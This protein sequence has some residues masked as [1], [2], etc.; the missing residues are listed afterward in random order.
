MLPCI[1]SIIV[2]ATYVVVATAAVIG[3]ASVVIV[4]T[5]R[6]VRTIE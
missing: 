2:V 6:F 1:E 3:A 5:N 4:E